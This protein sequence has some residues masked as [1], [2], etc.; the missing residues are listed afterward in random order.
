MC[1][2]AIRLHHFGV[3]QLIVVLEEAEATANT[4]SLIR[5]LSDSTVNKFIMRTN[6]GVSIFML[7]IEKSSV[8]DKFQ[9][10]K[11]TNYR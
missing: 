9:I 2:I 7:N 4:A 3:S 8:S 11:R 6:I 5:Q 10:Y 1:K